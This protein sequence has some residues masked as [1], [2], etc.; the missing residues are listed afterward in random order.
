[1]LNNV[2]FDW[3]TKADE[4]EEYALTYFDKEEV[5]DELMRWLNDE[6]KQEFFDDF[7]TNHDMNN[8]LEVE[9]A[10]RFVADNLKPA[11]DSLHEDCVREYSEFLFEYNPELLD[12]E[13]YKRFEY[14][15]YSNDDYAMDVLADSVYREIEN[16]CAT[17]WGYDNA[18]EMENDGYILFIDVAFDGIVI[19]QPKDR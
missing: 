12:A 17:N 2:T 8:D 7:F 18:K 4:M 10:I 15:H 3:C 1:M 5:Y 19:A 11:L 6:K 13:N 9:R 16:M 14:W